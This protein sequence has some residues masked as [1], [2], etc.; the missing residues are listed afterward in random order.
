VAISSTFHPR[1][2]P[3]PMFPQTEDGELT[4]YINAACVSNTNRK[5]NSSEG[6]APG[7]WTSD[8][9]VSFVFNNGDGGS[10]I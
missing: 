5:T 8:R 9:R 1:Y 3:S 2:V 10:R 7:L 6:D 4:I